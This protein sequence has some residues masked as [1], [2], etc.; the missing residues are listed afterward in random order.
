MRYQKTQKTIEATILDALRTGPVHSFDFGAA[1]IK[2]GGRSW[3]SEIRGAV[4]TRR[5]ALVE[6]GR[7][8]VSWDAQGNCIYSLASSGGRVAQSWTSS[9]QDGRTEGRNYCRTHSAEE[10][11]S[12]L[13]WAKDFLARITSQLG[14]AYWTGYTE[15]LENWIEG[16]GA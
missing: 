1:F 12:D 9:Y 6:E 3:D 13:A 16:L 14:E 5:H 2:A 10:R 15:I 8:L 4:S 11:A 7:V